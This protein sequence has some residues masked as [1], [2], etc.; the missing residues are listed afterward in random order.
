MSYP[1]VFPRSYKPFGTLELG[2]NSLVDVPVPVGVRD[3]PVFLV[4]K[5]RPF[6]LLWL[7]AP[8]D[9]SGG[10]WGFVVKEGKSYNPAVS[11]TNDKAR[12]SVTAR[13]SGQVV[14]QVRTTGSDSATVER[15]DL[16]PLGLDV[17]A[18]RSHLRIGGTQLSKNTFRGVETAFALGGGPGG[19]ASFG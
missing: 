19:A 9:S 3:T 18:D 15:L 4:G 12:H 13:V 6:P 7:A 2:S 14:L 8:S 17:V 1:Q 16:R 5:G 10:F 11:V